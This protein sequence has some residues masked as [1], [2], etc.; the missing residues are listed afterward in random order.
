MNTKRLIYLN[1]EDQNDSSNQGDD[2]SSQEDENNSDDW[3]D[4]DD[5]EDEYENN[6]NDFKDQDV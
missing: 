4:V 1:Q 5:W 2:S 6:L 3:E